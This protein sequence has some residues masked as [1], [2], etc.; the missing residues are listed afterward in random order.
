MLGDLAHNPRSSLD[1]LVTTLVVLNGGVPE[2]HN[3]FPIFTS[4]REWSAKVADRWPDAGP[5]ASVSREDFAVIEA[6][7]PF[8]TGDAAAEHP[9]AVLS[10]INNADKQAA[11]HGAVA[12]LATTGSHRVLSVEPEMPVEVLWTREPLTH[13]TTRPKTTGTGVHV[14]PRTPTSTP[15]ARS[16]GGSASRGPGSD[17]DDSR[18]PSRTRPPGGSPGAHAA[19]FNLGDRRLCRLCRCRYRGSGG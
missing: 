10:R 16:R 7:Q 4:D 13:R 1:D 5:L 9:L 19:S 2:R 12:W 8:H 3:A 17:G 15:T 6:A 11:L 14:P 18:H